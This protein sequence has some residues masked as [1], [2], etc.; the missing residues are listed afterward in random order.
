MIEDAN[1][2]DKLSVIVLYIETVVNSNSKTFL[3]VTWIKMKS[4]ASLVTLL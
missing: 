4:C 3:L 1:K 2:D